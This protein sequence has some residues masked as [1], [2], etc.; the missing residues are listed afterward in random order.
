MSSRVIATVY[1]AVWLSITLSVPVPANSPSD[2]VDS[3]SASAPAGDERDASG[4]Q[5]FIPAGEFMMGDTFSDFGPEDQPV[6]AVY[7]S[8]Y[9][10]DKYEVTNAQYAAA[11]NW[12]WAQG[13]LITVTSGR[14]YGYD[15]GTTYCDTRTSHVYSRIT[16][17]GSTFGVLSGKENHPM[18]Q[19]TWYG[20]L[21]F[22]N[23]RSAMEGKPLCYDIGTW[24]CDFDVPGYRLPTEAEWEKAGRGG[25]PDHRFPWSDQDTIQHA[26][27]NYDSSASYS[28]DTSPTR[29]YHPC[30]RL[31]DANMTSP[32]GWFD[33]SLHYKADWGWPG[34]PTSYQ[35]E[36]GA[37]GYG[38]HDMAGNVYE[39]CNDRY[40][41]YYYS[42]SPYYNPHGPST[43]DRRV[44][45]GGGWTTYVPR[46]YLR[47]PKEAGARERSIGLRCALRTPWTAGDLNCDGLI[48]AFDI[49]PFVLAL[50]DSEAY[51]LAYPNCDF[52]LADTNGDGLVNAFDIDPF[53]ILL[54]GGGD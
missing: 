11:L 10:I 41:H 18:T 45:R 23:W 33:G 51:A 1:L 32:V 12:A 2:A 24:T 4:E 46:V 40:G 3:F 9:Y 29:S 17:D 13:D 52:L 15:D 19:V 49:D 54:T 14:V 27:C 5:V 26:R 50:T 8:P 31:T 47:V 6:H 39:W 48:N 36:S 38:L 43:G 22:C 25:T 30:W 42:S 34:T 35:T 7:L 21:A 20:A 16:W 37:N 28:Y 44:M 53:V